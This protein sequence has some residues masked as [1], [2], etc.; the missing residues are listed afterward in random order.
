LCA[1]KK[2]EC[3]FQF[4]FSTRG[5][6]KKGK[7]KNISFFYF[8]FSQKQNSLTQYNRIATIADF[9]FLRVLIAQI[10]VINLSLAFNNPSPKNNNGTTR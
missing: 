1:Q 6:V 2:G 5:F 3:E 4:S 7:E 8:F 10:L 9:F